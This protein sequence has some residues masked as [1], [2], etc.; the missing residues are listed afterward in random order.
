MFHLHSSRSYA[1][2]A[3]LTD[4]SSYAF[5]A[6]LFSIGSSMLLPDVH[7]VDV[8]VTVRCDF[9][10]DAFLACA[11]RDCSDHIVEHDSKADVSSMFCRFGTTRGPAAAICGA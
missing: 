10:A 6:R 2:H 11:A 9:L 7:N 1:Q 8:P 4:R 5:S 3:V